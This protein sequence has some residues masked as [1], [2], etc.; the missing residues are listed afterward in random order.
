MELSFHHTDLQSEAPRV[1]P[2]PLVPEVRFVAAG[3]SM[4][5]DLE[6]FLEGRSAGG[7]NDINR[8]YVT[9]WHRQGVETLAAQATFIWNN[10]HQQ[11]CGEALYIDDQFKA[12]NLRPY[13][14][15]LGYGLWGVAYDE[16]KHPPFSYDDLF[17]S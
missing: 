9:V 3:T 2:H 13:I 10:Y 11:V 1:L 6:Q 5:S 8:W 16:E 15:M 7:I 14:M 12:L 17:P 4:P